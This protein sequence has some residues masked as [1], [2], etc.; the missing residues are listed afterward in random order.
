MA[1]LWVAFPSRNLTDDD[2][3]VLVDTVWREVSRATWVDDATW[4]GAV[5]RCLRHFT[6]LPTVRQLIEACVDVDRERCRQVAL[7][8]Q[9]TANEAARVLQTFSGHGGAANDPPASFKR[10]VTSGVWDRAIARQTARNLRRN[11]AYDEAH[12]AAFAACS[13]NTPLPA[14]RA[15]ARAA[16]QRALALMTTH[17]HVTDAEVDSVL[18]R[19]AA[20]TVP[21]GGVWPLRGPLDAALTAVLDINGEA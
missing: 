20:L 18:Y 4:D 10:A 3:L 5:S 2:R 17:P 7:A 13:T 8:E 14:R 11:L 6:W 16:G 9:L 21:T 19:M 12:G 15:F 1:R